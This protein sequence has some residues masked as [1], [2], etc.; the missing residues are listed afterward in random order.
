[1]RP[2]ILE[3]SAFGPYAGHTVLDFERLGRDGLYLISGD[4]GAGKTTIFDAITFALFGEAS[5]KNRDA[6]MLRSKYAAAD[7]PTEVRLSFDYGGKVYRLRRNPEYERPAKKGGGTT[8]EKAAAELI[9]P[10]GRPIT[11]IKDV[12][13]AIHSI[14][15]VDRNQFSQIA[16]I[17]QGDFL[18]LI[19]ADTRER[20]AIFRE[21]FAT[22]YYQQFQERLKDES[23]KA[24]RECELVRRSL[25][26]YLSGCICPEDD[27]LS[28]ELEK[29]KSGAA[30]FSEAFDILD[31]L[32][33]ADEA[34][35]EQLKDKRQQL[36]EDER[37]LNTLL[38]RAAELEKAKALLLSAQEEKLRAR[39]SL[40]A[41][42]EE[43]I[44]AKGGEA[45]AEEYG[46]DMA[47][48]EA[49]FDDYDAR[50]RI[51]EA[52]VE[53]RREL[54]REE[55]FLSTATGDRDELTVR[56]DAM[57]GEYQSL[58]KAGE[59]SE[60]LK[61]QLDSAQR[62][63]D[64]LT[65]LA[66]GYRERKACLEQLESAKHVYMKDI[67]LAQEAVRAYEAMNSAFLNE[68]AGVLALT[69]KE[70]LPCPVCGSADH[71][72]PAPLSDEAPTEAQLKKAKAETER[73][74]AA[75]EK[76]SQRAGELR[77]QLEAMSRE[78][79]QRA[80]S[81]SGID[82]GEDAERECANQIELAHKQLGSLRLEIE[83]EQLKLRR[84]QE[85]SRLMPGLE[86]K[87]LELE[88]AIRNCEEKLSV[89][90]T[91]LV[92]NEKRLAGYAGKLSFESKSAAVREHNRLLAQRR[93]ILDGI[94]GAENRMREA[95][96]RFD[97]ADGREAQLKEQLE[98]AVMPDMARLQLQKAELA[99]RKAT[100]NKGERQLNTRLATN[101]SALENMKKSEEELSRLEQR[102]SWLRA[103]SNT[104]NG[105]V[106]GKE[107]LMLET[108]VQRSFFDRIIRR[109]NTRFM[110]M[111]GGQYELIRRAEAENNRSQS[112][113]ELD[114]IDHYNGSQRSVK[115][116]SGGESFK[117]SLSLA[118][119][120][121]DEIQ[122]AAGGI[123]LD[124]MFVDEGF[125][126]LDAESLQQAMK[127]LTSLSESNRLVGI[128]SH[129]A[130]LKE[131]MDKQIVVT[132]EKS[133]GSRIE[134][135]V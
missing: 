26:Q 64:E 127:A 82:D 85:L 117:A 109:A 86:Q 42:S 120:L 37:Q 123:R 110:V 8:T 121:S 130:E 100:L 116:L 108:Y 96:R 131:R 80:Q 106:A 9:M 107:K 2:L 97:T 74:K 55:K 112:G 10:D 19:L 65:A 79:S 38:G 103:L 15:G 132:K 61:R 23:G 4:T 27:P 40:E 98:G 67:A 88:S 114:V 60:R 46:L 135:I 54:F 119:G 101:M 30:P 81:L 53:L 73:L 83:K 32:I 5:G 111:S 3:M 91:R 93:A 129:V 13:E 49:Q 102:W 84:R 115:T 36:E 95:Q 20:Q 41:L 126:S 6:A 71:P 87:R 62:R 70:G 45:Q 104:A 7:T 59:D 75:A 90:R 39:Q 125:G 57:N 12:N 122:S 25:E 58:E 18:K 118:L 44:K 24:G 16:M 69:L 113:L 128:I 77:G 124:T 89:C 68:Q 134:I 51:V 43:Y 76:S 29:V 17:A 72:A 34:A 99:D 47:A 52:V 94:A 78:L 31:K 66:A 28:I 133:G 33:A 105:N 11:R 92:E 35:L 21:I 14:L 1:M 63:K 56:L 48:L 50:D 22:G